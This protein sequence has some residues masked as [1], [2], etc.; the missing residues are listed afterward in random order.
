[1]RSVE[2][3]FGKERWSEVTS[4]LISFVGARQHNAVALLS[5]Y[6]RHAPENKKGPQRAA[7]PHQRS[8]Q[9]I[10]V[11]Q[12]SIVVAIHLLPEGL[13]IPVLCT[14]GDRKGGNQRQGKKC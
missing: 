4:G 3:L 8:V 11:S 5:C 14:S 13:H 9:L 6:C 10:L 7:G 1:M 2:N 12:R